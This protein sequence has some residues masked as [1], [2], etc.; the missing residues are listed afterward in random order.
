M[1]SV[2]TNYNVFVFTLPSIFLINEL[3]ISATQHSIVAR[4]IMLYLMTYTMGFG[5]LG[6]GEMAANPCSTGKTRKPIPA[7]ITITTGSTTTEGPNNVSRRLKSCLEIFY[8]TVTVRIQEGSGP[9]RVAKLCRI[10]RVERLVL[11]TMVSANIK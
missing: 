5:D 7:F 1:T 8:F 10:S 2:T 3:G 11:G 4:Q 9:E 6:F